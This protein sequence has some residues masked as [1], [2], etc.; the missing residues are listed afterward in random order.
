MAPPR[1]Q[2]V[3]N[4]NLGL[5]QKRRPQQLIPGAAQTAKNVRYYPQGIRQ[6]LGFRRVVNQVLWDPSV[7]LNGRDQFFRVHVHSTGSVVALDDSTWTVEVFFRIDSLQDTQML[8]YKGSQGLTSGSLPPNGFTDWAIWVEENSGTWRIATEFSNG[9]APTINQDENG[10]TL[11]PGVPYQ[12]AVIKD[13]T[14][15]TVHLKTVAGSSYASGTGL[16]HSSFTIGDQSDSDLFIGACPR[17]NSEYVHERGLYHFAGVIQEVRFYNTDV[18]TSTLLD[19]DGIQNAGGTANQTA[20]FYLTGEGASWEDED[21]S[22]TLA[23]A[24]IHPIDAEWVTGLVGSKALRFDGFVSGFHL[25]DSYLLRDPDPTEDNEYKPWDQWAIFGHVKPKGFPDDSHGSAYLWHWT[26]CVTG[27]TLQNNGNT[28]PTG[29]TSLAAANGQTNSNSSNRYQAALMFTEDP[30]NPGEWQIRFTVMLYNE[31][32]TQYEEY[33]VTSDID[34]ASGGLSADTTYKVFAFFDQDSEEISLFLDGTEVGDSPIDTSTATKTKYMPR[35]EDDPIG[36]SKKYWMEFGRKID[37]SRLSYA[38]PG[39]PNDIEI[40]YDLDYG[41][42]AEVD[43]LG[44]MAN[45]TRDAFLA[46]FLANNAI[47]RENVRSLDA[48]ILMLLPSRRGRDVLEDIGQQ[49]IGAVIRHD[50]GH[51]HAESLIETRTDCYLRALFNHPYRT[52]A[53]V[54]TKAVAVSSGTI[55]ELDGGFG[56]SVTTLTKLADGFRN[57]GHNIVM[58]AQYLDGLI[59]TSGDSGRNFHLWKDQ[60]YS[61]HID[62]PSMFMAFGLTDQTADTAKLDTGTY[63]YVATFFSQDTGK[64]S[65]IGAFWQVEIKHGKANVAMGNGAEV[66]QTYP[67]TGKSLIKAPYNFKG[68]NAQL[69]TQCWIGSATTKSASDPDYWESAPS[70]GG[71]NAAK[72]R[73]C[74]FTNGQKVVHPLVEDIDDVSPEDV[75]AVVES[76]AE[77]VEVEIY[78]DDTV[79][80]VGKFI[81]N[82][83]H[84]YISNKHSGTVQDL[85]SAA[86]GEIGFTG[87]VAPAPFETTYTGNGSTTGVPDLPFSNDPQVTHI[88]IWRT[89]RNGTDFR[90]VAKLPNKTPGFVD[91]TPDELLVGETLNISTGFPPPCKYVV[92]FGKR[93][94]YFGNQENPQRMWFSR[95]DEPWNTPPQNIV[96]FLDGESMEIQMVAR[97]ESVLVVA[98]NDTTFV[99]TPPSDPEFPFDIEVRMSDLGAVSPFG[100][101]NIHEQLFYPTEKG[102]FRFDGTTP[103]YLSEAIEPLWQS[104]PAAHWD[105][106][107]GVHYRPE[108]RIYWFYPTGDTLV[109]GVVVNDS[110]LTLDYRVGASGRTRYGWAQMTGTYYVFAA[111]LPD[112][113]GVNRMYV[114]DPLGHVSV[115]GDYP[116]FATDGDLTEDTSPTNTSTNKAH[117]FITASDADYPDNYAGLPITVVDADDGTRETRLSISQGSARQIVDREYS[118]FPNTADTVLVGSIEAEWIS[119]EIP[120][121]GGMVV[122]HLLKIFLEMTA[123]STSTTDSLK[124]SYLAVEGQESDDTEATE[125]IS[126]QDKTRWFYSPMRG[127]RVR[128]TVKSQGVA[129]PFEINRFL[130]EAEPADRGQTG[131]TS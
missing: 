4:L 15:I 70:S 95:L 69:H 114:I 127:R 97:T 12:I 76:T 92:P 28:E 116:S 111:F 124:V 94:L 52:A 74:K 48:N 130:L 47:T 23:N 93:M 128:L 44:F 60:L 78:P 43:Q 123:P 68:K 105:K 71:T 54:T 99:L 77:K 121:F 58:G 118:F 79:E 36:V 17:T 125:T 82:D 104:V 61:L 9:P 10:D 101:V 8:L 112:A 96:D 63:R 117:V 18:A 38:F 98:K 131:A 30:D 65:A 57:D 72:R 41:A 62:P 53:G 49:G 115:M 46:D 1:H 27:S 110:C 75:R 25:R 35:T 73:K 5:D 37:Q 16:A 6:S 86:S 83:A 88:E 113:N 119:G 87:A 80:I 81:G 89:H 126:N 42:Y 84:I 45:S 19:R 24:Y 22:A 66:G 51:V 33:S 59:L 102:F 107:I 7:Q 20:L 109:N 14:N 106:I 100:A 103:E 11:Y 55:Y 39:D 85:V 3:A 108:E 2:E 90:R 34:R 122:A 56:T 67:R 129:E 29:W 91:D 40:K 13:A 50:A 21:T 120:M 31:T 32:D 64:R 26:H